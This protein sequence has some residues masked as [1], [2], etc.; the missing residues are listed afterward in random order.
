MDG[1]GSFRGLFIKDL[2]SFSCALTASSPKN[3]PAT[4]PTSMAA[5]LN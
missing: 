4:A 1:I 5:P 3:A 2:I